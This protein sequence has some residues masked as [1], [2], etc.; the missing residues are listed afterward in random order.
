MP[1]SRSSQEIVLGNSQEIK[2]AENALVRECLF[3]SLQAQGRVSIATT[4][5]HPIGRADRLQM[6]DKLGGGSGRAPLYAAV[7]A[8]WFCGCV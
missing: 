3:G 1:Y 4:A 2:L 6:T 8:I 7:A 5:M